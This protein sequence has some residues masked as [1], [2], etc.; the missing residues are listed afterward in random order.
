MAIDVLLVALA[1]GYDG[2]LADELLR[3]FRERFFGID[4]FQL[5][6]IAPFEFPAQLQIPI[7]GGVLGLGEFFFLGRGAVLLIADRRRAL[8]EAP[9]APVEMNL[10]AKDFVSCRHGKTV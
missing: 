7:L 10:S 6:K 9:I 2:K 3:G 1:L 5:P 4:L 8:P